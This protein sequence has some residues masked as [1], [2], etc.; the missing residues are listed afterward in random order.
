[1]ERGGYEKWDG[2]ENYFELTKWGWDGADPS[3]TRPV[4][5]PSLVE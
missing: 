5:I 1:M 3:Q 2:D 4:V